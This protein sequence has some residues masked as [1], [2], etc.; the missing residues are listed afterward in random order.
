M[1]PNNQT[2][3]QNTGNN[4]TIPADGN[5]HDF[6]NNVSTIETPGKCVIDLENS[7]LKSLENYGNN[8]SFSLSATQPET[9]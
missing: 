2:G 5:W 7:R 9:V 4:Q 8:A 6:S 3:S 1:N